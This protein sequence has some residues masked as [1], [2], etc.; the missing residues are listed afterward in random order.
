MLK[1]LKRGKNKKEISEEESELVAILDE[2]KVKELAEEIS[3]DDNLEI[4][5]ADEYPSGFLQLPKESTAPVLEQIAG[6]QQLGRIFF[7]QEIGGEEEEKEIKYTPSK[8]NESSEK[9]YETRRDKESQGISVQQ[10][11]HLETEKRRNEVLRGVTPAN[12]EIQELKNNPGKTQEQYFA[13]PER[14]DENRNLPFESKRER[15]YKL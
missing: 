10:P 8:Y 12:T 6:Q 11:A 2:E 7:S 5:S 13:T 1:K 3:E 4:E 9:N 15:K 14:V